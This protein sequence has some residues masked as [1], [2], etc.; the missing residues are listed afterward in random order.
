MCI[1]DSLVAL[2]VGSTE[3][4]PLNDDSTVVLLQDPVD[5]LSVPELKDK[6]KKKVETVEVAKKTVQDASKVE[7]EAEKEKADAQKQAEQ[8]VKIIEKDKELSLIHISEP[9]RP[10]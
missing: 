1:R 4:V 10:Y 3:V 6:I 8:D 2:A 7:K 5:E 9:T